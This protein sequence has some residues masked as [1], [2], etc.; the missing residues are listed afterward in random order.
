MRLALLVLLVLAMPLCAVHQSIAHT[1]FMDGFLANPALLSADRDFGLAF[2]YDYKDERE[3][4]LA[5]RLPRWFGFAQDSAVERTTLAG[6]FELRRNLHLGL[7]WSDTPVRDSRLDMG[8]VWRPLQQLSVGATAQDI[9]RRYPDL[10]AGLAVR[11]WQNYITLFAQHEM[12]WNQSDEAFE[13]DEWQLGLAAAPMRGLLLEAVYD[14][15]ENVQLTLRADLG[16][17]AA[18]FAGY[19]SDANDAITRQTISWSFYRQNSL[20]KHHEPLR[21]TVQP[22]RQSDNLTL[23]AQDTSVEALLLALHGATEETSRVELTI[24]AQGVPLANIEELR[25]AVAACPRPV[26][27]YLDDGSLPSLYLAAAAD[28]VFVS[29]GRPLQPGLFG[30]SR[31]FYRGLLQYLDIRVDAA[32]YGEL[33]P[34]DEVLTASEVSPAVRQHMQALLHADWEEAWNRIEAERELPAELRQSMREDVYLP[35]FAVD[36]GLADDVKSPPLP[37]GTPLWHH[38]MPPEPSQRWKREGCIAVLRVEGTLLPGETRR[39]LLPEPPFGTRQTGVET[40]LRQ[41]AAIEADGNVKAVVLR[42]DSGGGESGACVRLYDA[43]RALDRTKPVV[44]S[45]GGLCTSGAL[46]VAS[47]G[48]RLY[49]NSHTLTGGLS[50]VGLNVD[51]SGLWSKLGVDTEL[52]S[53]VAAPTADERFAV[54]P[55]MQNQLLSRIAAARN[56][57]M[58]SVRDLADGHLLRGA[59]AIEAGLADEQ[60]GLLN[61]LAYARRLTGLSEQ[62]GVTL[63]HTPLLPRLL[64]RTQPADLVPRLHQGVYYHSGWLSGN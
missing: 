7:A 26:H 51:D 15:D 55:A 12:P 13:L 17:F 35:S 38:L 34:V 30:Q 58:L 59:E 62:A 50:V 25:Q 42:M 4:L 41:I 57:P 21:L 43:L 20:L 27:A 44:V 33:A 10:A 53:P 48:R 31:R 47:A 40:I 49:V 56:M 14:S 29:P 8:A 63:P 9:T 22:Q 19:G 18:A 46:Y 54:L 39:P 52:V 5:V 36:H 28:R 60:G 24:R 23:L 37:R 32:K 64:H 2:R 11:P 61:A 45:A 3:E 16:H 1:S 6:G